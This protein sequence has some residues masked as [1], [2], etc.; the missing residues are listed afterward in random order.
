ME[1]EVPLAGGNVGTV[2]RVG[3][4]VRRAVG[5]WTDAV[6]ELLRHLESVGFAYSPRVLGFDDKG[7]EVLTFLE[8]ETAGDHPWPR[9]VWTDETLVQA[10]TILREYHEAAR[11]FRPIGPRTWRT[12]TGELAPDEIV[13]HHDL[14]PYNVVHRDGRLV[15]VIDWDF[16]A[17]ASPSWDLAFTAWTFAPIHLPAHR[18]ELGAP[19]DTARRIALLCDAYGLEDRGGLLDVVAERMVASIEGIER[20]AAAGDPAFIRLVADGH[21]AR[22]RADADLLARHADE[23]R[24]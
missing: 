23:W 20:F 21:V 14:A 8:G 9:W 18:A 22:M 2:V 7:R 1:D 24:G 4:T 3:D 19:D 12:V 16:A 15:G 6:H 11:D 5:P 13:G 10:G 17:P